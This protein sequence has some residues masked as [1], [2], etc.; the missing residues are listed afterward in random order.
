MH[1]CR[2]RFNDIQPGCHAVASRQVPTSTQLHGIGLV[3][4]FKIC[5]RVFRTDERGSVLG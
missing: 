2:E 5:L 1:P 3:S 4:G